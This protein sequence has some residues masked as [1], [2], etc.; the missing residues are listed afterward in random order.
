MIET[1]SIMVS[2]ETYDELSKLGNLKDSFDSV[3]KKLLD[4]YTQ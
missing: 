1:K 2:K 3:I 4:N